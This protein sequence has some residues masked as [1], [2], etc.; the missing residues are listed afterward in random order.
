M[1][2]AHM[3]NVRI[4]KTQE[5]LGRG[6]TAFGMPWTP[7]EIGRYALQSVLLFCAYYFSATW[8]LNVYV[9]E[10]FAAPLWPASGIALVA[11]YFGGYHLWPAIAFA[12][13][14]TNFTNDAP[15]I[16]AF[17]I[18]ISNTIEAFIATYLLKNLRFSPTFNRLSDSLSFI[19][20]AFSAP[21]LSAVIGP[22]VLVVAGALQ[23][24]DIPITSMTWWVADVLG[25]LVIAPF[26]L[27]WFSRPIQVMRR[28]I[29]LTLEG[30]LFFIIIIVISLIIFLDPIPLI[31][32]HTLPYLIFIPLTWGALRIGP[33]FVT[34]AISIVSVLATVGTIAGFGPFIKTSINNEFFLLQLFL[35]N[36]STI[37]LLFTSAI[38]E[39]KEAS[40]LLQKNVDSLRKDVTK[41]S[42]EDRA[43]NEFIA[44]LSHELRNPLAPVISALE[45]LNLDSTLKPSVKASLDSMH[46]HIDHVIRL[47]DD[48]LNI[49]RQSQRK[50]NLKMARV[51]LS[52]VINHS[53]A[54]TKDTLRKQEHVLS[55]HLSKEP[56]YVYA[57]EMRLEQVVVNL[58]NNAAKYTDRGGTIDLFLERKNEGAEIRIRDNG[59]GIPLQVQQEIF[60]PFRQMSNKDEIGLGIGLSLAKHF[61]ELHRGTIRVESAGLGQGSEFIVWLPLHNEKIP[62]HDPGLSKSGLQ[63]PP[64][65]LVGL[66]D[67]PKLPPAP[68]RERTKKYRTI[69]IIDTDVQAAAVL[70]NILDTTGHS[71][72]TGNSHRSALQIVQTFRPDIILLDID[73]PGESSY[74]LAKKL[75]RE[76]IPQPLIIALMNKRS[77]HQTSQTALALFDYQLIKPLSVADLEFI[78]AKDTYV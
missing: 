45:L 74:A 47:L 50:F 38:E 60:E 33:R 11:L 62:A 37:F 36:I 22:T 2:I 31:S 48:I 12:A 75:R 23:V 46:G 13:F 15:P 5:P 51:D 78:L 30:A 68:E 34:A 77:T 20:T 4:I 52:N 72:R 8:A 35:I 7:L 16:A 71:V 14:F 32:E 66:P 57:D 55:S 24:S 18:A 39:R 28:S 27:R 26:I 56:L 70:E 17:G 25:I 59:I 64:Q 3:K 58:L 53:I 44:I 67:V 10:G 19:A 6:N 73:L 29:S 42:S 21:F 43:K 61:I 9:V 1:T 40:I 63:Q 54:S 65:L 41:M 49:T 76:V 69:L